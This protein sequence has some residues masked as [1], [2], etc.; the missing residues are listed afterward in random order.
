MANIGLPFQY[1]GAKAFLR[2]KDTG[3]FSALGNQLKQAL[4]LH[5][6]LRKEQ[7][8]QDFQMKQDVFKQGSQDARLIFAA[9]EKRMGDLLAGGYLEPYQSTIGEQLFSGQTQIKGDDG[10]DMTVRYARPGVQPEDYAP[11]MHRLDEPYGPVQF[12]FSAK[13]STPKAVPGTDYYEYKGRFLKKSSATADKK[14]SNAVIDLKRLI[15]VKDFYDDDERDDYVRS[16]WKGIAEKHG[17]DVDEYSAEW[18]LGEEPAMSVE[19]QLEQAV[20]NYRA[21][22]RSDE[23]IRK[24][25]S[26][27]ARRIG[28]TR[29]QIDDALAGD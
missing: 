6:G 1:S 3:R 24:H 4:A 19:Q 13:G 22:G 2:Q 9:R 29:Q 26:A 11:Y 27:N 5:L 12:K 18:V 28:V 15:D 17:V 14:L 23:Y 21:Q 16:V 20:E 25:L 8:Q 10:E 7:R